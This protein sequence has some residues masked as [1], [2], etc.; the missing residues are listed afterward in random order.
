LTQ[1]G[2]AALFLWLGW[3]LAG[4]MLAFLLSCLVSVS[5][6][7]WLVR[8]LYPLDVAVTGRWEAMRELFRFSSKLGLSNVANFVLLNAA[9]FIL[10][11][12]S[13]VEAGLYAAASRLTLL[14][15]L[16]IDAFGTNVAP[17]AAHR[18][19][20]PSFAPEFQR[21]TMWMVVLSAPIFVLLFAFAE[22]WMMI[23]GPEFAAAVPVLQIL[24][25][26]QLLNMLTGN[27]GLLISLSHRPGLKA[28]N[29]V[30]I[31]GTNL[32]LILLLAPTYG[33]VGAAVAYL[34]AMVLT[35]VL[36]YIEARFI[37][38]ISPWSDGL[39]KPLGLIFLSGFFIT[40][41]AW[42]LDP[43][44]WQAIVLSG[45][46]AIAYALLVYFVG[47]PNGD[48]EMLERAARRVTLRKRQPA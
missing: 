7:F 32:V 4:V 10:G 8:D 26:A 39:L 3:G 28:L 18:M 19:R 40:A 16:F 21:M 42:Q 27:T 5:V 15:L 37:L 34:V 25:F 24:A 1:L 33:A 41:V 35:D 48:R 12:F 2:L 43:S 13:A 11:A 46:Y 47:L 45:G 29:T 30:L 31:W 20:D 17:Q 36:E 14:G 23:V 22:Q 6:T 9:L 44:F 38:N